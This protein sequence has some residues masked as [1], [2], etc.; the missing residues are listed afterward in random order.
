MNTDSH[1]YG[2]GD[3]EGFEAAELEGCGARAEWTRRGGA[4]RGG[5]RGDVGGRRTAAA[6]DGVDE[7][8]RGEFAQHGG[9]VGGRFVVATE[10]VRQAGVGVAGDVA[11]GELREFFDVGAHRA[12]AEG[13]VDADGKRFHVAD[14]VVE[15]GD[16]L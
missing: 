4:H 8:A 7:A 6:A 16:G 13:A 5:D 14:G 9:H 12:A 11:L 3:G 2:S 1:G 15:R 10:G